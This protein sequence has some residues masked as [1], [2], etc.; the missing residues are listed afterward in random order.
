L[1][2]GIVDKNVTFFTTF[3]SSLVNALTDQRLT[4]ITSAL[5]ELQALI[6]DLGPGSSDQ[7]LRLALSRVALEVNA[8]LQEGSPA[9]SEY[10]NAVFAALKG[11]TGTSHAD[12]RG[13]C[14]IDAAHYFYV[15]GRSFS[16]ID[17]SLEAVQLAAA[18]SNKPL[19]RKGLTLAGIM[20]A[21]TGNI[22]RAIE[23][24]AH[25]LDLAHELN[26]VEAECV[27]WV[28]L[29]VALLYAAQYRDAIGCFEH[30]IELVSQKPSLKHFRENCSLEHC[31]LLS[32][33]RR[34]FTGY[35]GCGEC[36]SRERRAAFGCGIGQSS[37]ARELLHAPSAGSKQH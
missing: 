21:D 8:K 36:F 25:A 15:I 13:N 29:G 37:P 30:A 24:Y 32:S 17:P 3:S 27:V 31:P 1:G 16:A 6:E 10:M 19:L 2:Q 35:Q 9:S 23:S 22:S 28:N 18:A 26:D 33:S 20:Y 34:L 5:A 4:S 14:L 7:R 11:L 12:L